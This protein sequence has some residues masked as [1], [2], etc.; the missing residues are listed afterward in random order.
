MSHHFIRFENVSYSYPSGRQALRQLSFTIRHGEKVAIVGPNGAGKSTLVRHINGLLLPS[1]GSINIGD[2]PVGKQTVSLIRKKVGMVFQN[3]D[4]QL[5]MPT[6]GEDVAFGPTNM[7]LPQQEVE[8]RVDMA[9]RIVGCLPLRHRASHQLSEGEKRSVALA[10]VLAMEP[11]ILVLDEPSSSLDPH[12]R[13]VLIRQVKEF[14]HTCIIATH[15]LD[16]AWEVCDRIVVLKDGMVVADGKTREVLNDKPLLEAC[17][18]EQP[19]LA[20]IDALHHNV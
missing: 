11:D 17:M 9:L 3:P 5:F 8:C 14:I 13:R 4:D 12:A 16:L 18:L 19:L 20:V 6:A 1:T 7:G 2:I 15:D 10:T